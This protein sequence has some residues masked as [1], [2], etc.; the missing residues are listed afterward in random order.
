VRHL[1]GIHYYLAVI[2]WPVTFAVL[3]ILSVGILWPM[4]KYF[5]G[6]AYNV[7]RSSQWGDFFLA[8]AFILGV[9]ALRQA[10]EPLPPWLGSIASQ[11]VLLVLS[12]AAA[13]AY[14]TVMPML[15]GKPTIFRQEWAEIYHGLFIFP[16]LLYLVATALLATFCI[17]EW[18]VLAIELVF[19]LVW[20]GLVGYDG[21]Y[22][23]LDQQK[24]IKD[25]PPG[26][27]SATYFWW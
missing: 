7:S 25:Y 5:E 6:I 8:S 1:V 4:R 2:P 10:H 24:Y 11:V 13:T 18:R 14:V 20:L 3:W 12:Y 21:W 22:G 15:Q 26:S 19:V 23:M 27:P 17:G 16:F 9:L